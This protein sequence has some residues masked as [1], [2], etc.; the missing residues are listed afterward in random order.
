MKKNL[1]FLAVGLLAI[2]SVFAAELNNSPVA[3]AEVAVSA[4]DDLSALD[5]DK[6]DVEALPE[7]VKQAVAKLGE[8]GAKLKEALVG[9]TAE[10]KSVFKLMLEG[11]NG[12]SEIYLDESGN[13]LQTGKKQAVEEAEQEMEAK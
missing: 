1:M 11:S 8:S 4:Q 3:K 10:G 9:K 13:I 7:A 6:T 12:A 5:Y 2:G